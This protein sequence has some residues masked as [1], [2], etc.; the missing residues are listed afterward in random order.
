MLKVIPLLGHVDAD[1]APSDYHAI[2]C[3]NLTLTI[4]QLKGKQKQAHMARVK[5]A[6]KAAMTHS[7]VL[8]IAFSG[9]GSDDGLDEKSLQLFIEAIEGGFTS[10]GVLGQPYTRYE[11]CCATAI[12]LRSR[13]QVVK[14]GVLRNLAGPNK[15]RTAQWVDVVCADGGQARLI[16]TSQSADG[17]GPIVRKRVVATMLR[18]AAGYDLESNALTSVTN[19]VVVGDLNIDKNQVGAVAKKVGLDGQLFLCAATGGCPTF[20]LISPASID[21]KTLNS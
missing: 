15:G 11:A 14:H 5:I 2:A 21:Y 4:N 9:V 10:A 13:V 8:G 7:S 16:N 1:H 18:F 12:S 6:S 17:Y 20:P 19:G 3:I